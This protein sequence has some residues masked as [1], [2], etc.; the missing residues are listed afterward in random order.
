MACCKSCSIGATKTKTMKAKDIVPTL[1]ATA[2]AAGGF[3]AANKV[4]AVLPDSV[5]ASLPKWAMPAGKLAIG[6]A[7][8]LLFKGKTRDL[9]GQFT[10]GWNTE[11]ILKL[12]NS[13]MDQPLVAI[14]GPDNA[15]YAVGASYQTTGYI[16]GPDNAR[17]AVGA[18]YSYGPGPA[19]FVPQGP[20]PGME[21]PSTENSPLG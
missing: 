18:Q 4:E 5:T 2:L 6:I 7:L 20:L 1:T 3:V 10:A 9:V 17:Y 12:A 14:S 16:A 8:P 15:R 11:A 13:F 21:V 19:Q